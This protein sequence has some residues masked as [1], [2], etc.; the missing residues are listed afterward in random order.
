[1]EPANHRMHFTDAGGLPCGI[2]HPT[3]TT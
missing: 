2:D 1:M 3:M